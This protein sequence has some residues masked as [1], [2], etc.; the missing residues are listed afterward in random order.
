MLTYCAINFSEILW[1]VV[2]RI[3]FYLSLSKTAK[4]VK[5][6]HPLLL[7]WEVPVILV[8][9]APKRSEGRRS[10]IITVFGRTVRSLSG[11]FS[12]IFICDSHVSYKHSVQSI[13]YVV[14][15]YAQIGFV[16][17]HKCTLQPMTTVTK[18]HDYFALIDFFDY[19]FISSS[20]TKQKN[21]PF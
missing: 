17:H 12:I 6:L 9:L 2:T 13:I 8:S 14:L 16:V 7:K 15:Y 10:F 21:L 1:F 3:L 5:I 4:F 18:I 20:L 19:S 11:S